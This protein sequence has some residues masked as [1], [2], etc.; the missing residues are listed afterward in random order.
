MKKH[1][2]RAMTEINITNLVDVTMVLLIIFMITAPFLKRGL[3]VRLP[4]ASADAVSADSN[5]IITL[6]RDSLVVLN[7]EPLLPEHFGTVLLRKYRDKGEAPV[8][9]QA[10]RAVPYGHVIAVMNR[11]RKAG[12]SNLAL[13]VEPEEEP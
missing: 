9:L 11:L 1:R 4:Q 2:Y 6:T 10:D 8:M 5:L 12:I 13:L 7:N 3:E